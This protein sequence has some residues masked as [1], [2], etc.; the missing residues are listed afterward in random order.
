MIVNV[1]IAWLY[2]AITYQGVHS[3][4]RWLNEGKDSE[5]ATIYKWRVREVSTYLR[6]EYTEL[7]R[8]SYHE[9]A[10]GS[11]FIMVIIAWIFRDPE[12]F[13]GWGDLYTGAKS[14]DSTGAMFG[15]ILLFIIPKNWDFL[16]GGELN[17]KF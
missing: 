15:L 2:L 1:F 13:K 6:R 4:R 16:F 11:I 17:Y 10:V 3:L 7:G 12:M 8:M 14:G 5:D 9:V